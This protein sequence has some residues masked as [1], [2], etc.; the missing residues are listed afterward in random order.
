M[1]RFLVIDDL[2][3]MRPEVLALWQPTPE[4]VYARTSE[5]GLEQLKSGVEWTIVH[6]DHDL[7]GN[8]TTLP[9]VDY[10]TEH[11]D[12]FQETAFYVHTS[13]P[14]GGD[15][16]YKQL[17]TEELFVVLVPAWDFFKD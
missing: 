8:D 7:G 6:F 14:Y 16:I 11:A 2:R 13:N 3:T 9:C 5:E 12:D 1:D 4:V 10:V 15:T 17:L